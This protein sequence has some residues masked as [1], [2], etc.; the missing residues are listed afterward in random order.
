MSN[1]DDTD[2]TP[3]ATPDAKRSSGELRLT[4]PDCPKCEGIGVAGDSVCGL[5][6]G[7]RKVKMSVATD[8]IL[9]GD[10]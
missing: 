7:N 5:C 2:K 10:K 4:D 6:H 8:W 9:H 3:T 1:P